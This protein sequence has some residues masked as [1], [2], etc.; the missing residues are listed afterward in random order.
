MLYLMIWALPGDRTGPGLETCPD[1][2]RDHTPPIGGLIRLLA[3]GI[4]C[5]P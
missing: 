2:D 4:R 5:Y 1:A 3:D